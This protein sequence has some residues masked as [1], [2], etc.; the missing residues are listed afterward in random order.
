MNLQV[1][2]APDGAVIISWT[3][4]AVLDAANADEGAGSE[5][6]WPMP[7]HL[8]MLRASVSISL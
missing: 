8:C 1:E 7:W 2:D 4:P 5:S 3:E 6:S